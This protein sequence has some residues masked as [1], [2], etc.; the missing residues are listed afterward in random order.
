MASSR[1]IGRWLGFGADNGG[2]SRPD[3]ARSRTTVG[4]ARTTFDLRQLD[5]DEFVEGLADDHHDADLRARHRDQPRR[6]VT[7]EKSTE[8]E[9]GPKA[10]LGEVE[11]FSLLC[12]TLFCRAPLL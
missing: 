9:M 8:L 12:W 3:A 5:E 6:G 11:G 2:A 10:V 7:T 4:E 1:F